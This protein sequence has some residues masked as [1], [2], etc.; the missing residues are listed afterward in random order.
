MSIAATFRDLRI[1]TKIFCG[2]GS[3]LVIAGGLA[4]FGTYQLSGLH[5]EVRTMQVLTESMQRV[6]TVNHAMETMRRAQIRYRFDGDKVQLKEFAAAETEARDLLAA[7]AKAALSE[8]RRRIYSATHESVAE[9]GTIM[10]QFV[11]LVDQAASERT[12]LI[13]GGD[14]LTAATARLVAEAHAAHDPALS[15]AAGQIERAILLVRVANWRF[16]AVPD[17]SGVATL[18]TNAEKASAAIT[19]MEKLSNEGTVALL[20][21]I[22]TGLAGYVSDFNAVSAIIAKSNGIFDQQLL[23]KML[24]VQKDMATAA[25]SLTRSY[26]T[27]SQDLDAGF[28]TTALMQ[29][30]IAAFAI[31]TGIVLAVLVGRG[32]AGPVSSMTGAMRKLAEGDLTATVPESARRDEIGAMAEAMGIFQ[33]NAIEAARRVAEQEA[34]RV[35]KEQRAANLETLTGAFEKTAGDLVAMVSSAAAE[36]QVTAKSMTGTAGQTTQ[37]ATTVAAAAEEASVNV[38]T[39]ASAAEELAASIGEISRQVGQSAKIAGKAVEDA[40]RT[41]TVV[42]ALAEGAQKIGEVVG[43]ISNIAGQTNLLALNATIEAARAG[44]AGKGFAVVASEVKSLATQTAKATDDIGRHIAQIQAATKE[45]VESIQSIGGTIGE[46]SE[47]AANIAAAVE[48]QGAATQEIARNVQQ[49]AIGTTEVT[50]TITGVSEGAHNT[51]AAATQLLGAAEELSRQSARLSGEVG[52][53]I[54]GVKAA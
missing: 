38:Q 30:V 49:A 37:Q 29:Q 54:A 45:A 21:A 51:G 18:N 8:D 36:L 28:S 9:L 3:L 13:A 26:E 24:S 50:S 48:E 10:R 42:R 43:L 16:L 2:F 5:H 33:R 11:E 19:A 39:V 52:R 53:F 27:T 1:Q 23:P 22:R 12:T 14:A 34:E 17:Q 32:I 47:I 44:D 46:V 41:D 15:D 20:P 4:G 40:K 31:I 25:G 7:S 35:I 6:L